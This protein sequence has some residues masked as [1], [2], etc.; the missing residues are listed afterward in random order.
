[1]LVRGEIDDRDVLL[2]RRR[3]LDPVLSE[4]V[5]RRPLAAAARTIDPSASG[6]GITR[7]TWAPVRST[8]AFADSIAA[9]KDSA[10]RSKSK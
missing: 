3:I 7:T 10:S 9:I 6:V 5:H 2:R 8:S 1:M 4:Q